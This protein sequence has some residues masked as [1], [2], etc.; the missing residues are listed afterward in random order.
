M[1]RPPRRRRASPRGRRSRKARCARRR[2]A[3]PSGVDDRGRGGCSSV[4]GL[5]QAAPRA[6]PSGQAP[7]ERRV[8]G[9]QLR[10]DRRVQRKMRLACVEGRRRR[11]GHASRRAR[12]PGDAGSAPATIAP[13][14]IVTWSAKPTCPPSIT[15][16][17]SRQEPAIPTCAATMQCSPIS[18]LWPTWTRLSILLPRP[19]TVSPERGAVD[20]GVGADLHVVLDH[21]AAH[22][23]DLPVAGRRPARSRTRRRR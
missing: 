5:A 16:R 17:P 18:T 14:P 3:W 7:L 15:P 20:R 21:D 23:R 9:A 4:S 2:R 22:L 1:A 19:T 6:R 12:R 8:G 10:A 13:S 11:A